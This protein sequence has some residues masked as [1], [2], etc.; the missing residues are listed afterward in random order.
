MKDEGEIMY[1]ALNDLEMVK[2]LHIRKAE[3]MNDDIT[4]INYIPPQIYNRYMK[5]NKICAERRYVDKELKTQ[6]RFGKQDLEILTKERGSREPFKK[7]D[8]KEFLEEETLPGFDHEIKWSYRLD[9]PPRKNISY[10]RHSE[11]PPSMQETPL[12]RT[13]SSSSNNAPNKKV[14]KDNDKEVE[15][16]KEDDMDQSI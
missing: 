2:E 1:M 9:R 10:S 16:T 11:L 7:L 14:R 12:S 3:S 15:K 6:I 8:L 13:S 5:L 4:V